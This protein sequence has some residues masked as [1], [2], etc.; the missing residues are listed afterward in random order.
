MSH[1]LPDAPASEV[2]TI[3]SLWLGLHSLVELLSLPATNPEDFE[4]RAKGWVDRFVSIYDQSSVTPYMHAM[5]SHVGQFLCRHGS[6]LP[7]NQQGLKKYNDRLTC[8]FF[9]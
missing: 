6:L 7:F 5:L 1:L 4:A 3:Q 2:A 9:R 8:V